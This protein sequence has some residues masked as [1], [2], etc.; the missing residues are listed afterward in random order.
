MPT[1]TPLEPVIHGK[2]ERDGYTIEKASISPA[3]RGTTS[4]ATS[5]GRKA[6]PANCRRCSSPHGH[7]NNGRFYENGDKAIAKEHRRRGGEDDFESA[8]YPLQARCATCSPGSA[9][10]SSIT[11]WS[12]TPTARRSSIGPSFKGTS[13]P[14][15]GCTSFMGI[16]DVEQHPGPRFPDEP[17]RRRPEPGRT[18]PGAS[19]GS[20]QTFTLSRALRRSPG[21]GP[22][23]LSWF[24]DGDARRLPVRE[25]LRLRASSTGNIE[26]AGL[27]APRPLE[28][29]GGQ[30]LDQGSHDEGA[31][32][33]E[34]PLRGSTKR[35]RTR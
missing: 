29:V 13:T 1:K 22:L 18:S 21:R 14:R 6:R 32:R 11:T 5:I 28:H 34:G 25:L 12:V 26:I 10:S 3:C 4:A 23:P 8:K 27:W 33:A 35:P 20:T 30:R 9:A 15:C 2:I 7:W 16:A 19:G 17:A 24:I 31:P